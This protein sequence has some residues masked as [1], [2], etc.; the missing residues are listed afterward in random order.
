MHVPLDSGPGY[1]FVFPFCVSV[2]TQPSFQ[3]SCRLLVGIA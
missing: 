1:T 3:K 2:F